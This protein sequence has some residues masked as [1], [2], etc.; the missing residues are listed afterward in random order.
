MTLYV[1]YGTFGPAERHA[2][3][4][5]FRALDAAGHHP[6]VKRTYGCYGT[7]RLFSGR[8]S[9]KR[10]TGTFKVPTLV[11]DNGQVIDGS[12]EIVAWAAANPS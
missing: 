12:H 2:C 4:N 8:R 6:A 11:P 10:L 5:A 1:C 3:S 7:D 9:V